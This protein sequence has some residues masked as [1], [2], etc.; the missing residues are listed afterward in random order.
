MVFLQQSSLFLLVSLPDILPMDVCQRL[1]PRPPERYQ[2]S[3]AAFL[4]P[5][6][7]ETRGHCKSAALSHS[8]EMPQG[9][10]PNSL[11]ANQN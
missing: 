11:N 8:A 3:N 5:S 1:R 2:V 6:G 4:Y 9:D 10:K 7:P